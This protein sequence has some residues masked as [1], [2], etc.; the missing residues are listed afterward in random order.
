MQISGT[1]ILAFVAFSAQIG[2]KLCKRPDFMKP[3]QISQ[4]K[5]DAIGRPDRAGT[6]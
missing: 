6:E 2:G 3:F 1:M 4:V 5:N